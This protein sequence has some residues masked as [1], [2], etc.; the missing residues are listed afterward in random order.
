M[1]SSRVIHILMS[2]ALL[3]FAVRSQTAPL[4]I[5]K[6]VDLQPLAAQVR[7]VV[8]ALDFLGAP[9]SADEARSLDSAL[10]GND[11]AK[12]GET[13]QHILDPHCLVGL[14]INP[15][16]RVKAAP[17]PAAPELVADGWRSFLIKV[18]NEAGATSPLRVI[19]PQ[20]QSV[21]DAT[22]ATNL[23]DRAYAR[24]NQA[25]VQLSPEEKWLD[26]EMLDKQPLRKDLSGLALEY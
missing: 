19:S 15:E 7:R 10:T 16:M 26:L 8:E 9:L 12:A 2:L 21:H 23:S 14:T 1:N 4:P 5:V 25:A 13:I 22:G 3:P 11:A 6:E 20:A 17:G 18:Q 24:R